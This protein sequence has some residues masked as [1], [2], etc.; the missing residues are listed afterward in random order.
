MAKAAKKAILRYVDR[1][2]VAPLGKAP[3][4]EKL[5]EALRWIW[6]IDFDLYYWRD[7]QGRYSLLRA[8]YKDVFFEDLNAKQ[9]LAEF[10]LGALDKVRAKEGLLFFQVNGASLVGAEPREGDRIAVLTAVGVHGKTSAYILHY[11]SV[12]AGRDGRLPYVPLDVLARFSDFSEV[13]RELEVVQEGVFAH[14][15]ALREA[16]RRVQE[17]PLLVTTVERGQVTFAIDHRGKVKYVLVGDVV[18][19]VFQ[20]WMHDKNRWQWLGEYDARKVLEGTD[21]ELNRDLRQ[22][23]YLRFMPRE[24][25]LDLLR[26]KGNPEEA[27]TAEK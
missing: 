9:A 6:D 22:R 20:M 14:S 21:E 11:A 13:R 19:T 23:T 16:T 4:K 2:L 17:P 8:A 15:P 3:S 10:V 5:E 27:Q 25:V 1:V 7:L 26:G 12:R 18:F 24:A